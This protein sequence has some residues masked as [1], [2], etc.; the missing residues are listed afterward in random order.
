MALSRRAPH[1]RCA[2]AGCHCAPHST[3]GV[4]CEVREYTVRTTFAPE[5]VQVPVAAHVLGDVVVA[6]SEEPLN[7]LGAGYDNAVQAQ[8]LHLENFAILGRP[9]R[10]H[11]V[12]VGLQDVSKV[13]RA[14]AAPGARHTRQVQHRSPE[15]CHCN[16]GT[17]CHAPAERKHTR[18]GC[19]HFVRSSTLGISHL[20]TSCVLG[21]T[22]MPAARAQTVASRA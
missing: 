14:P 1:G 18:V 4:R 21:V 5:D 22:W 15:N 6:A 11:A 10:H 12:E 9:A 8:H 2:E 20:S 16:T 13:A 3:P 17:G 19:T 7:S